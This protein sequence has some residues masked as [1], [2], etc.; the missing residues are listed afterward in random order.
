MTM[1][2]DMRLAETTL[3]IVSFHLFPATDMQYDTLVILDGSSK[4][5]LS[6]TMMVN[7]QFAIV[8]SL[9]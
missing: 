6:V 4:S 5:L 3:W 8:Y 2:S 9:R 1:Q 7:I